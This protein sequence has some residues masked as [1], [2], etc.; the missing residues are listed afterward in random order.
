MIKWV[1]NTEAEEKATK[2]IADNY[3]RIADRAGELV[4]LQSMDSGII[5]RAKSIKNDVVGAEATIKA[6][7][8]T[9]KAARDRK[10]AADAELKIMTKGHTVIGGHLSGGKDL[11]AEQLAARQL[12]FESLTAQSQDSGTI[13][14]ASDARLKKH[15]E[16]MQLKKGLL[17]E[18]GPQVE[19]QRSIE[20]QREIAKLTVNQTDEQ[21][22]ESQK[23]LEAKRDEFQREV[24]FYKQKIDQEKGA[25]KEFAEF[26]LTEANKNL[27]SNETVLGAVESRAVDAQKNINLKKAVEGH[28]DIAMAEKARLK[29]LAE[30]TVGLRSG[31]LRPANLDE[32]R[33]EDKKQLKEMGVDLARRTSKIQGADEHTLATLKGNAEY[34]QLQVSQKENEIAALGP[35]AKASA[36]YDVNSSQGVSLVNKILGGRGEQ[37]VAKE[38]LEQLKKLAR[39]AEEDVRDQAKTVIVRLS[40]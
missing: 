2:K 34:R 32:A 18:I 4:K 11:T 10:A 19:L 16:E 9:S 13:V 12:K 39:I 37:D 35:D 29:K 17:R 36:G 27:A 40:S 8:A 22:V 28:D 14:E 38:Q 21:L 6:E 3:D 30:D 1:A 5:D 20:T 31:N 23:R 7:M 26:Q 33:E 25:A 24:E 15:E